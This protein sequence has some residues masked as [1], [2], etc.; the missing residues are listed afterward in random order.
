MTDTV[1]K[2]IIQSSSEGTDQATSELQGLAKAYDGVT[3]ASQNTE[4][5]TTSVESKFSALER[6]LGTST[7]Q[8]SQFEKGVATINTALA[9]NPALQDRAYDA[10]GKLEQRYGGVSQAL[11][12][13]RDQLAQVAAVQKTIDANTGV[14]GLSDSSARAADIAAYGAALDKLA[15][16]YDPLFAA[17]QKYASVLTEIAEAERVGAISAQTATKARLDQTSSYNTQVANLER[18]AQVQKQ[19]AQAAVN[20]QTIAPDRGADIAAY[21]KQ[22]DDLR[23]KY[24]PLFAAGQQYKATLTEINQ[25]A[26]TGALTES[27]RAAA[28]MNT[29][30]AFV[31]QVNTLTN[32]NGLYEL[33]AK[34]AKASADAHSGLSTQGQAAFHVIRSGAEQLAMGIPITQ[35]A[36]SQLNHLSFAMT[37]EGGIKG[38]FTEAAGVVGKFALALVNPVTATLA[39]GA[40][41]LYLGNSWS[42][43]SAQVS[44]AVIG[45]GA[46]TG[47]SAADLGSFAKANSSATGLTIGEARN[48]AIEFTK[49]GDIAVKNLKGVGDAVHGYAV[50]TG[51]DA[52]EATK[53]LAGALSG[54]LVK[55]AENLNKTYMAFDASALEYIQ[56]LQTTGERAKA[57]QFIV[58]SIAPANQRAADSVSFLT[59]TYQALAGAMSLIKN[60]PPAIVTGGTPQE[61]L[62]QAKT[63]QQA[64]GSSYSGQQSGGF[65]SDILGGAD[66]V[67]IVNQLD[68]AIKTAQKD[69]D[70]F[71]GIGK[72]AFTK[73][74]VEARAATNAILPQI[75]QIRQLEIALDK[76]QE[77]KSKGANVPG[78]DAAI[79]AY[80]IQIAGLKEQVATADVYNTRVK[81]ISESWGVVDQ[82]TALALQAAKNQLPVYEAVGGA[83]KMAAQAT[84]DYKNYMDQGKT[85]TEASALAASN[86]AARMAQVKAA[87]QESLASL[88]DQAAVASAT[89]VQTQISAQAR[90][91]YNQLL[92]DG[93]D[94][95]TAEAVATQQAANSRAQVNVQMERAVQSSQ[96]QLDLVNAQATGQEATVKAAIAYRD[97][98]R[99]GATAT[100]AAAIS[101]NTLQA[102]LQQA[103]IAAAAAEVKS[104]QDLNSK[105]SGA[106]YNSEGALVGI[107]NGTG[108]GSPS[109]G[110]RPSY[111]NTDGKQYTSEAGDPRLNAALRY[112]AQQESVGVQGAV[113][114]AYGTG[115]LAAALAA[116]KSQPNTYG[117]DPG[118]AASLGP[119]GYDVNAILGPQRSVVDDKITS[120]D[121]LTQLLNAKTTDKG[122]QVA[123]LQ[124]EMEW[125][126]TLPQSLARDQKIVNLQQSIDQLKNA[127][128]ANTAVTQ[129]TLNPLYNGRDALRIGYYKAASGLDVIAQGPTSGDQ[130]PF[131]AMI[132]GGE[133]V[134]I[135]TAAEQAAASASNDN[136]RSTT[137]NISMGAVSTS[138]ERRVRRQIAQGYGQALA[139]AGG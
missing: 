34:A 103:A 89:T 16:K 137:I 104:A 36:T 12:K 38:A 69:V 134:K 85:A 62:Q 57:V 130:V 60:G 79:A 102:S 23:A 64:A 39:L 86:M 22:L 45:I 10:L 20:S 115:G 83:A 8:M 4:K 122:A 131:H 48:V 73:L 114:V 107:N 109:T 11:Q 108:V 124:S 21:G 97:A 98:M 52:T 110:G 44:R 117:A 138:T 2:V 93:V 17:G 29:K 119:K 90:A 56:T 66:S 18:V 35:V 15:A 135:M 25:A 77:A 5:S 54:D 65:G 129:A 63:T 78:G 136:R 50:L 27:E 106:V 116:A 111:F 3:V 32:A 70:N 46:A 120:V 105:I 71:G 58:D 9:Q 42:E 51:K 82:Q 139:A 61:R 121:N 113:D 101:A 123:N 94:S 76:L 47:S 7:G 67:P 14:V 68:D 31:E 6:R 91:T 132:N 33:N 95:A 88:R 24:N 53:D 100:Q 80:Q 30:V 128:D 43:S 81:Q 125:L 92:R 55:G 127:T 13:Q 40:A 19:A 118:L 37:G 1:D 133:R 26:K 99:A 74:S 126:Q 49:T 112:Q 87:A 75:E 28:V 41:G 84:A 59:K 72:E 96:D